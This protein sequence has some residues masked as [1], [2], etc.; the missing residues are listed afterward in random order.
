MV[1]LLLLLRV[2]LKLTRRTVARV[3]HARRTVP[4]RHVLRRLARL[5]KR[6][7]TLINSQTKLCSISS[8]IFMV[9][10]SCIGSY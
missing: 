5:L 2:V 1:L 7:H 9:Y 4:R 3:V 10:V 6:H 8:L